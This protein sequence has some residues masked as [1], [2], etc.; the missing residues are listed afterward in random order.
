MQDAISKVALSTDTPSPIDTAARIALKDSQVVETHGPGFMIRRLQQV[1]VSFFHDELRP[2]SLTPL[3]TTVLRALGKE[4]GL[5]QVSLASK[6]VVDASTIKDVVHRLEQ[7]KAVKRK[8]S[9]VDKRMKIVELTETGRK[10]LR[11]SVPLANIAADKLLAPL[12]ERERQQLLKIIAKI[13]TAHDPEAA[14]GGRT[15]WRRKK[16]DLQNT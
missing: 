7:N 15:T 14:S 1:S 5:D 11:D 16:T 4:N 10:L 2:L 3:Q 12:T 9:S 8:Q 13:V 6:A